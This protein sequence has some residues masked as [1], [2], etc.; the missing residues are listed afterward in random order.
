MPATP[1]VSTIRAIQSVKMSL[2]CLRG[3]TWLAAGE[4]L[5]TNRL[6]GA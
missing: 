5:D 6:V 1:A 2:S 3:G 4:E